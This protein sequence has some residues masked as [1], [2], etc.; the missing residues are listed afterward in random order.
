MLKR[1]YSLTYL[2]ANNTTRNTAINEF[3]P[4]ATYGLRNRAVTSG[5]KL[6]VTQSGCRRAYTAGKSP[7]T[8]SVLNP[9]EGR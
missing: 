5:L 2:H 1:M 7:P 6:E 8:P 3:L 9:A 4:L